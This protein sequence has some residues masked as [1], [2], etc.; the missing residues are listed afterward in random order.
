MNA[1]KFEKPEKRIGAATKETARL[2]KESLIERM[3]AGCA[4]P[5]EKHYREFCEDYYGVP[6]KS[7]KEFTERKEVRAIIAPILKSVTSSPK[8]APLSIRLQF[9]AIKGRDAQLAFYQEHKD[10]LIIQPLKL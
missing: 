1:A 7:R 9:E 4:K 3:S 10:A 2:P 8:P 6:P 5:G